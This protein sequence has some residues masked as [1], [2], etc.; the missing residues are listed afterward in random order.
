MIGLWGQYEILFDP[1]ELERQEGILLSTGRKAVCR[2]IYEPLLGFT[3]RVAGWL[4][5]GSSET[6]QPGRGRD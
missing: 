6:R 3:S 1:V 4:R 5:L 2:P